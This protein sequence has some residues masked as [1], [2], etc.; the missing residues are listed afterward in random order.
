MLSVIKLRPSMLILSDSSPVFS[1]LITSVGSYTIDLLKKLCGQTGVTVIES[2]LCAII[3]PPAESEYAVP[4][5][6]G[7]T[8]GRWNAAADQRERSAESTGKDAGTLP[9][10]S[11]SFSE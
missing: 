3:G 5:T 6:A 8:V 4:E 1:T 10:A 7:I 9:A 2:R 11:G